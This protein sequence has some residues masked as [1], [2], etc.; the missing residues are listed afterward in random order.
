MEPSTSTKKED[1][2]QQPEVGPV[3]K[4]RWIIDKPDGPS[5]KGVCG[6]CGGEKQFPNYIEG[7][8]WGYDVSVKKLSKNSKSPASIMAQKNAGMDEQNQHILPQPTDLPS[9]TSVTT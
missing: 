6:Q 1:I 4:H 5:S 3:C 8:S 9:S 2:R 7:S